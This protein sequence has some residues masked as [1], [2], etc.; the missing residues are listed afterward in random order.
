LAVL[1]AAA[2]SATYRAC[3]LTHQGQHRSD[4]VLGSLASCCKL[5][6]LPRLRSALP[7]GRI[8]LVV[9]VI[10]GNYGFVDFN[11]L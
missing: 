8:L 4:G 6:Y 10:V 7:Y 1:R 5:S 9:V 2:S 3:V 11:G